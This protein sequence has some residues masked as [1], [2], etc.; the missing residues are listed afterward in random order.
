MKNALFAQSIEGSGA[1]SI[2]YLDRSSKGNQPLV[3]YRLQD[4]KI[5]QVFHQKENTEQELLDYF[6]HYRSNREDFSPFVISTRMQEIIRP[7][8][9]TASVFDKEPRE[10]LSMYNWHRRSHHGKGSFRTLSIPSTSNLVDLARNADGTLEIVEQNSM[11]SNELIAI[12]EDHLEAVRVWLENVPGETQLSAIIFDPAYPMVVVDIKML[13]GIS[14]THVP[15]ISRLDMI[16]ELLLND[17]FEP[18]EI[19]PISYLSRP[20]KGIHYYACSMDDVKLARY[21]FNEQQIL[22]GYPADFAEGLFWADPTTVLNSRVLF[23]AAEDPND[24][25]EGLYFRFGVGLECRES[26]EEMYIGEVLSITEIE[27]DSIISVRAFL[28][29]KCSDNTPFETTEEIFL[30]SELVGKGVTC[31]DYYTSPYSRS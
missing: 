28:P 18:W 22:F 19:Y 20:L 2:Y 21:A 13:D 4:K 23:R 15:R 29:F 5:H 3:S 10:R 7:T 26:G 25:H 11:L 12:P 16:E 9:A 31:A 8:S 27:E 24:E 14:L 17:R 30:E 6:K 1:T